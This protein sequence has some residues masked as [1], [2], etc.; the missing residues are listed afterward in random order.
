MKL[1]EVL[2]SEFLKRGI[3]RVFGVPGRENKYIFF[4]EVPE[5]EF[6]TC[7]VEFNAGIMAEFTG[8]MT[9]RPQ[10]CFG[11]MGPGA[12]N[13][14]T[15]AASAILNNSPLLIITAQLESDDRFYNL[16]HQCVNQKNF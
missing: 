15:A 8:R 6:I 3:R 7:R 1:S 16:T 2:L 10:V 11:T 14:V 9:R 4:N 13:L 5:I 12:T